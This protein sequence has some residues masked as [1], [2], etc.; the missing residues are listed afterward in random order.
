MPAS[1]L[2]EPHGGV[3]ALVLAA[4]QNAIATVDALLAN[5]APIN[6]A[7]G[8]G[9]T[10]LLVAVQNAYVELATHLIDRGA[11]VNLANKKG[12]TPLYLA[13]KDR[14]MEVGTMP[15]PQSTETHSSRSS[16]A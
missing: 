16:N 15:A 11:D 6:Q 8:D 14:S 2:K 10:A 5:G 12:W 3:T 4:R 13:V 7:S 9:S 1:A